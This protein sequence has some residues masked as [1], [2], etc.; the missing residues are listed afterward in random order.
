[1]T[2]ITDRRVRSIETEET[3]RVSVVVEGPSGD[4]AVVVPIQTVILCN[5]VVLMDAVAR[6]PAWFDAV[7]E[8]GLDEA[9]AGRP[10]A[11]PPVRL[12]L[13]ADATGG[14]TEARFNQ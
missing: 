5:G 8:T 12:T 14:I 3:G 7:R 13:V 10:D 9:R 11:V 1:M 2:S 6:L 4:E